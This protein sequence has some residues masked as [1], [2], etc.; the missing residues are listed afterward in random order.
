MTA[1]AVAAW[2]TV[3]DASAVTVVVVGAAAGARR[4]GIRANLGF[5]AL[6][7][8]LKVALALREWAGALAVRITGVS[9]P[10][11]EAIGFV[12]ALTVGQVVLNLVVDRLSWWLRAP[13][14]LSEVWWLIDR[15]TGVVPG[16]ATSAVFIWLVVAPMQVL[17]RPAGFGEATAA[18]RV[19]PIMNERLQRMVPGYADLLARTVEAR[20]PTTIYLI[21]P[22]PE[23]A[24]PRTDTGV[25][26]PVGE[27][28]LL[29][30]VNDA[31]RK[32]G[33]APLV[34]DPVLDAVARAHSAEMLRLGYFEHVSPVGGAPEARVRAAGYWGERVAEN[35]AY[36][37][38]VDEA[39]VG[40]M[41]SIHHRANVVEPQMARVGIGIVATPEGCMV[42][43]AFASPPPT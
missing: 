16:A 21:E 38:T 19:A 43:Q 34:R 42:T 39:H 14:T 9:G 23:V 29:V 31:R 35:I 41:A 22:G 32:A 12:A 6:I 40:L 15:A 13:R 8:S 10:L 2:S 33:V 3:L 11:G 24:V 5:V 26:D 30:L 27:A 25:V 1:D 18:S 17:D 36:A 4:G 20:K 28:H 7:T 37:P